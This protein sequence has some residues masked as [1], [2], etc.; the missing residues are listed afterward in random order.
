[1]DGLREILGLTE[2]LERAPEVH[3][4]G[5]PSI[6]RKMPDIPSLIVDGGREDLGNCNARIF[7]CVKS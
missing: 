4:L 5:C 1:M 3:S 7:H 6:R 2:G